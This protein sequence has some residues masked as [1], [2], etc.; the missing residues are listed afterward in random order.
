MKTLKIT[1]D[2]NLVTLLVPKLLETLKEGGGWNSG[3][4]KNQH[5]VEFTLVRGSD[6]ENLLACVHE[7][8]TMI[9]MS[10]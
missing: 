4:V 5:T 9:V 10:W 2:L 7:T 3:C 6:K 1:G 8:K